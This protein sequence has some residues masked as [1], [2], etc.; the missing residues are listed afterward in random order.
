M[1]GWRAFGLRFCRKRSGLC[2]G[3]AMDRMPTSEQKQLG[4]NAIGEE[5]WLSDR[6]TDWRL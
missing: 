4:S 5:C 2:R 6:K 3:K 1:F